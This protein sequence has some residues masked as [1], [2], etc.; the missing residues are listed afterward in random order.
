MGLKFAA[1][2]NG[3][4]DDAIHT[5]DQI[6]ADAVDITDERHTELLEGQSSGLV[7][8]ANDKGF[9][10]LVPPPPP[11]PVIITRISRTQ[12]KKVLLLA[13]VYDQVKTLVDDPTRPEILRIGFYDEPTWVITDEFVQLMAGIL[14]WDKDTLQ[15]KFNEAS[16]L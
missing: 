5:A 14:N 8:S 10:V 4:Y 1:S 7:I 9:P 11:P 2:T 16:L 15:S 13:G 6:P 3:F 12:G